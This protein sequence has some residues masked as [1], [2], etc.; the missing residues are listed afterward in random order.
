M[1]RDPPEILTGVALLPGIAQVG[2]AV[3]FFDQKNDF[4]FRVLRRAGAS[5]Q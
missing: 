1:S 4:G 2:T 3:V 5:T